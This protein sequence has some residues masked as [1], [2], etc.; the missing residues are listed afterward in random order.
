MDLMCG[1]FMKHAHL[2][3][4]GGYSGRDTPDPISNSEVKPASADGTARGTVWE[5]RSSPGFNMSLAAF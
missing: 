1:V 3:V 4:F 2:K 5:S